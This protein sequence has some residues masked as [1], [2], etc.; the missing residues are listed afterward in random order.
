MYWVLP[1]L[2]LLGS[3]LSCTDE[4]RYCLSVAYHLCVLGPVAIRL[5]Q[6]LSLGLI[7]VQLSP[8]T[9]TITYHQ[10]DLIGTWKVIYITVQ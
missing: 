4:A 2:Y 8:I 7:N 1:S 5:L 10:K 9:N 3:L 6:V